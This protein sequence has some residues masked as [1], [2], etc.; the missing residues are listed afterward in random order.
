MTLTNKDQETKGNMDS[1][2]WKA[3]VSCHTQHND[4]GFQD[5]WHLRKGAK[6]SGQGGKLAKWLRVWSLHQLLAPQ[7]ATTHLQ[8]RPS[9]LSTLSTTFSFLWLKTRVWQGWCWPLSVKVGDTSLEKSSV[10]DGIL[11]IAVKEQLPNLEG[12]SHCRHQCNGYQ[13]I[14]EVFLSLGHGGGRTLVV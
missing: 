9:Q 11:S 1:R 3:P 12:R 5:Y 13:Q 6:S 7:T 2:Q 14:A 4:S 8:C 10:D